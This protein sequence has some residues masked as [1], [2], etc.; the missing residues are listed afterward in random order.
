MSNSINIG[1]PQKEKSC[2]PVQ[3]INRMLDCMYRQGRYLFVLGRSN[4]VSFD[5]ATV[6]PSVSFVSSF[7]SDDRPQTLC[8]RKDGCQPEFPSNL[9]Q[10]NRYDQT[11]SEHAMNVSS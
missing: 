8:A 2:S 9:T 3:Q 7:S 1:C 10:T 6:L 11:V 5:T 4:A